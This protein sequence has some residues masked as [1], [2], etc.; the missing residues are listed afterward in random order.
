M[1][2]LWSRV[3]FIRLRPRLYGTTWYW[4]HLI[5]GLSFPG[6]ISLTL[7]KYSCF[8]CIQLHLWICTSVQCDLEERISACTAAE[9]YHDLP[10][11]YYLDTHNS[12]AGNGPHTYKYN[13]SVGKTTRTAGTLYKSLSIFLSPLGCHLPNSSSGGIMTSYKSYSCPERVW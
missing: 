11:E 10:V 4:T 8:G 5:M 9:S 3:W 1:G 2:Q 12:S 13:V 6:I 7:R